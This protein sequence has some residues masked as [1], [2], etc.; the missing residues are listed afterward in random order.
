MENAKFQALLL[1]SF[2]LL[3]LLSGCSQG[4]VRFLNDDESIKPIPYANDLDPQKVALGGKLFNDPILSGDGF[5][6]CAFCHPLDRFGMDGLELSLGVDNGPTEMNTPT[7]FNARFNIA[8]FWD[9]RVETL[10][11]QIDGPLTHPNEMGSNWADVIERLNNDQTYAQ[12]FNSV[13]GHPAT[14]ATV[15]DAIATFERALVT[16][17][18]PFDRYLKGDTEALTQQQLAGYDLFKSHGCAEC[19]FG[20]GVGGAV[21]AK[22]GDYFDGRAGEGV[23]K[24]DLGRF[25]VT[26]NEAD[27]F[28]FKVPSLRNVAE[29]APYFHD[30]SVANLEE[31]VS[32]MMYYQSGRKGGEEDVSK[33]VDFLKTLTGPLPAVLEQ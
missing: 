13:F 27:R 18:S 22:P 12:L 5:V 20:I 19:H 21:F 31:A 30:G 6:S 24:S 26:G 32:K 15:K 10:E 7:V 33:I 8:Q 25:N 23:S 14:V 2:L 1:S 16:P 9:G 17:D 28:V 29:T 3:G 4:D 11:D